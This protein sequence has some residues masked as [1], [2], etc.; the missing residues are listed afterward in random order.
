MA[1]QTAGQCVE[2][3]Q[4]HHQTLKS[5]VL[6]YFLFLNAVLMKHWVLLWGVCSR[7]LFSCVHLFFCI[8]F[9]NSLLSR[10]CILPQVCFK[11]V[12]E[13]WCVKILRCCTSNVTRTRLVSRIIF[14]TR[15]KS[16]SHWK[17]TCLLSLIQ[18]KAVLM[19]FFLCYFPIKVQTFMDDRCVLHER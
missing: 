16:L 3:L 11:V 7:F 6:H 15:S 4:M 17:Q 10:Y 1:R 14:R 9:S 2:W 19:S 18:I 5:G 12:D 8:F 13:I